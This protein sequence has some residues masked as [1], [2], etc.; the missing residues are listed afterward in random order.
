MS[1]SLP[2]YQNEAGFSL[3]EAL[4]TLMIISFIS[5]LMY[6]VIGSNFRALKVAENSTN[7]AEQ[8]NEIEGLKKLIKNASPTQIHSQNGIIYPAFDGTFNKI[9][10]FSRL[11]DFG[12]NANLHKVLI[13][14][15]DNELKMIAEPLNKD[16]DSDLKFE[17]VLITDIQSGTF[18]FFQP[19]LNSL[20][21]G[22]WVS[23]WSRAGL[24]K[25]VKLNIKTLGDKG[26]ELIVA[27]TIDAAFNC[28]FDP[29]SRSCRSV[30]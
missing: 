15:Q 27:P 23:N 16:P 7:K 5:L 20:N 3:I 19:V 22:R 24:P 29:V 9:S 18:S 21:D 25:L 14:I 4:I 28:L 2:S 12:Q 11:S 26:I 30:S 8:R 1:T 6:Q 10:F 13:T 17:K